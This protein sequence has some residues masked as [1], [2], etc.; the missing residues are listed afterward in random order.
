ML[1]NAVDSWTGYAFY[2]PGDH[3]GC[4]CWVDVVEGFW[5]WNRI[6]NPTG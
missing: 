5:E 4:N 6:P 1:A 2:A 3:D